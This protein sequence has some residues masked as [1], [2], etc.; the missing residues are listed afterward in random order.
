MADG[1]DRPG[2]AFDIGAPPEVTAYF[3]NRQLRP[4]FSWEDM[5]PEEHAIAFS[6]AKAMEL[7]VLEALQ[8]S[9]R[10]AIEQGIPY[11]QWAR[12][13]TPRLQDL[14]WW[15]RQIMEDPQTGEL[16]EVQLG[17]P[18]RLRTIYRA[19]L[20]SARAAGQWERIQ[21]TRDVLPYLVYLLGPS[22]R[23]RPHHA[24][25][26]GLVLPADDPFWETWFPPNGW[27]CKCHVRQIGQREAERRGIS[28]APEV[29]RREVLNG[30]T[31]EIRQ[32]PVGIDPGWE[33]NPGL[34]R[35]RRMEQFLADRLDAADP[36]I[37]RVAA[38][39]MATSWRA[40][41]I[42]EGTATGSVPVAMLPEDLA[43]HLGASTRVVQ[44]SDFT[45]AK[46]RDKRPD[47]GMNEL[48]ELDRA[49]RVGTVY[50]RGAPR[51][52]FCMLDIDGAPWI[53]AI[54]ATGTGDELYLSTFYPPVREYL[55]RN[56]PRWAVLRS[57][58]E[59]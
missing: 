15:G 45:A 33:G 59:E 6:V 41:R 27:G 17:S 11:R 2:Y 20:R 55:D 54:K 5:E 1:A 52:L 34:A 40:R 31:G 43:R 16:R 50:Q 3:Q 13:L 48:V 23:H 10:D 24:E 28:E 47:V 7:D 22:E 29:R 44:Y 57:E 39:D 46:M 8:G 32:V 37:A 56:Q 58:G 18:R 12:D 53:F 36:D 30:R 4:S 42:H 35:Q 9:L 49:L 21:R 51:S 14:G 26:E 38:R 19:N 25:K